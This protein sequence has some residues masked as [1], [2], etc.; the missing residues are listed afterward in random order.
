MKPMIVAHRGAWDWED[1]LD[2]AKRAGVEAAVRVGQ[3]ILEQ[4]GIGLAQ[5]APKMTCAW[6]NENGAVISRVKA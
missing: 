1:K 6:I 3:Q 2:P 4:G 5:S